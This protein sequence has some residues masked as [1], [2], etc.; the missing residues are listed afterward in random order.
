MGHV[1]D[2]HDPKMSASPG[3]M[4]YSAPDRIPEM[5]PAP[6]SADHH[7]HRS[8]G[9]SSAGFAR[10]IDSWGVSKGRRVPSEELALGP[11]RVGKRGLAWPAHPA[12]GDLLF[13]LP[14]EHHIL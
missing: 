6:H 9:V 11:G 3:H 14:L 10:A 5:T 8:D 4:A 13:T 1:D 2:P 7:V 12:D